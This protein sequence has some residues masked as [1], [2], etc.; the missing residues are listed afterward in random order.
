MIQVTRTKKPVVLVEN[1]Q[2]WTIEYLKAKQI[3]DTSKTPENKKTVQNIE[4][5][6]NHSDVKTSLKKMFKNKC[7]FCESRITHIDYG[8]IE[9]FKPKSKYPNL[10]F[11]WEN[12]LLSCSIC[13][14]K[15]NKGDKF[16]L[17]N[18]D[19]PFI[20]P[21]DENPDDFLKFEFDKIT[22]TFLIFPKNN[23][24]FTTIK[25]LGL[26]RDDLIENR[27]IELSKIIYTLDLVLKC[28]KVEVL[29]AFIKEFSE[30]DQYYA[31]IKVIFEKVK[32]N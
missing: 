15:S 8:Q 4:K 5:R 27:T 30:K 10:C 20:N 3:Y 7:A 25:E 17:E 26:D 22:Q 31:F 21:V 16:P 2:N 9:H 23:R 19:G 14:G 18:E 28:N 13:N 1:A 24:G 12:F 6:Y 32:N 11:D 29:E